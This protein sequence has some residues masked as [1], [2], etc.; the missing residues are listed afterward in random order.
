[1]DG[2]KLTIPLNPTVFK[3][4][5]RVVL[6]DTGMGPAASA[7]NPNF[8]HLT[9]NLAAAGF[10]PATVTD[11]VIS[12]F[13]ADH[14]NGLLNGAELTYPK[15]QVWVPAT[16]WKYWTDEGEAAKAPGLG[17]R[18]DPAVVRELAIKG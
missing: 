14:I 6:I 1:M 18:A 15:A 12:H 5:N 16:E 3:N 17:F 7:Q 8:G 9:K 2:D 4:G 13:H 11:V 10:D